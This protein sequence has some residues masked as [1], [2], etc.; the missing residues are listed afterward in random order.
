M[1]LLDA[2]VVDIYMGTHAVI[3]MISP[4]SIES[5][6]YVRYNTLSE[7]LSLHDTLCSLPI[8]SSTRKYRMTSQY[9]WFSISGQFAPQE[10]ISNI[11]NISTIS[12]Q[13]SRN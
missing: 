9:Y 13:R 5:L 10:T 3:F 6:E 2:S 8:G 1:E 11:K 4:S 7:S 12:S